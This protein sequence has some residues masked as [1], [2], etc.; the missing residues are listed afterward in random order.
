MYLHILQE[1]IPVGI[2]QGWDTY[3]PLGYLPPPP[4]I[5]TPGKTTPLA[6]PRKDLGT[7]MIPPEET[8]D[9]RYLNPSWTERL[10]DACK[11]ITFV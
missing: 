8:R 1:G 2:P 7:E 10:T 3:P 11:N 5:P 4:P 6:P 9:Q